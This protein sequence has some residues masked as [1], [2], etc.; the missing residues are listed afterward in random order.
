[1]TVATNQVSTYGTIYRTDYLKTGTKQVFVQNYEK[2]RLYKWCDRNVTPDYRKRIALGLPLP[3]LPYEVKGEVA[4]MPV[5]TL[6]IVWIPTGEYS[7]YDNYPN[8]FGSSYIASLS[9][10]ER[11]EMLATISYKLQAKIKNEKVNIGNA[12]AERH[13]LFKMIAGTATKIA[14]SYIALKHGN[15][16]AA[17]ASLSGVLS[18]GNVK[19]YKQKIHSPVVRRSVKRRFNKSF[20]REGPQT[21]AANAWLELQYGWK[22]LIDDLYGAAEALADHY[23]RSRPPIG[24]VTHSIERDK[25]VTQTDANHATLVG[26]HTT[27]ITGGLRYTVTNSVFRELSEVGLTNPLSIAWEVMP[28]SFVVDWFIPIGNHLNVLDAYVGVSFLDGYWNEKAVQTLSYENLS[29][30]NYGAPNTYRYEWNVP[31]GQ[32]TYRT[33]KRT[34]MSGFPPIELPRMKNPFSTAHVANALALLTQAFFSGRSLRSIG[35]AF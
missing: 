25:T 23:Y 34:V 9:Q 26:S 16:N 11:D 29:T 14:N 31:Y 2:T 15:I 8:G 30:Y 19:W 21:A 3:V 22:P 24:R 32:A 17:V 27:R 7:V 28:F 5:G 10:P 6:K 12:L 35:T 18:S 33:F 20:N 4:T 1:M 13:Q